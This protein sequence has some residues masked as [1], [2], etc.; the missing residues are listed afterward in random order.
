MA[1]QNAPTG[2]AAGRQAWK[3]ALEDVSQH[4]GKLSRLMGNILIDLETDRRFKPNAA[5]AGPDLFEKQYAFLEDEAEKALRG[6]KVLFLEPTNVVG[7]EELKGENV[8][9]HLNRI[10]KLSKEMSQAL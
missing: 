8:L 1:L 2:S 9:A 4:A 5:S 7:L 10:E 6:V 3:Q